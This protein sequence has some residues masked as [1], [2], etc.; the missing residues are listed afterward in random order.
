MGGGEWNPQGPPHDPWVQD[1][2]VVVGGG[3]AHA[4]QNTP[5]HACTPTHL[6]RPVVV[7]VGERD[8]VLRA[9]GAADDELVDVVELVPVLC[10]EE[11]RGVKG[12]GRVHTRIE[13]PSSTLALEAQ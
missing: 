9:D 8:L 7:Q 3:H 11:G 6:A 5:H 13:W 12:E 10:R 2:A 4:F 1:W